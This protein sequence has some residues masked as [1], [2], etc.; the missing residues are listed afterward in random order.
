MTTR[1]DEDEAPHR[2][3]SHEPAPVITDLREHDGHV[4]PGVQGG[5]QA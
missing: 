4:G 3:D 1:Y 2:S 5:A